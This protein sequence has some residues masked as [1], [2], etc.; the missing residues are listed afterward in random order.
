MSNKFYV[1]G[2]ENFATL[3]TDTAFKGFNYAID[4]DFLFLFGGSET[5][6]SN[7]ACSKTMY[8]YDIHENTWV[9]KEKKFLSDMMCS[10]V[11]VREGEIY[12]F[13]GYQNKIIRKYSPIA[14]RWFKTKLGNIPDDSGI[15]MTSGLYCS[16]PCIVGD[17]AYI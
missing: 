17:K 12:F 6:D 2:P 8:I 7:S 4:N 5:A 9:T 1:L 11:C 16:R 3:N 10:S 14:D 13:G 15:T